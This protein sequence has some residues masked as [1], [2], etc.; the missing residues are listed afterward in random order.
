M[1][2]NANLN[3]TLVL[4]R[5]DLT[6]DPAEGHGKLAIVTYDRQQANEVYVNFDNGREAVY[7][8]E[9][10]LRLKDKNTIF[11]DL[12]ANGTAMPLDRFKDLYKIGLLLD[13]GTNT[14]Q[15]QALE[16]AGKNP[17][18]WDQALQPARVAEKQ[19]LAKTYSR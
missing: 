2:N 19:V 4:V 16:L 12:K 6:I 8:P 3:G 11:S 7:P 14:A 13:R 18:I 1:D 5:P 17:A 15:W 10:L 9:F